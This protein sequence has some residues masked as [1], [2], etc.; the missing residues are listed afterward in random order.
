LWGQGHAYIPA[1]GGVRR[2]NRIPKGI[3]GKMT[4]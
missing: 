3:V 1:D 4:G 2:G